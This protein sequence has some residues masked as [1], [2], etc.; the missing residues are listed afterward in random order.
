MKFQEYKEAFTKVIP[1]HA[2]NPL[3]TLTLYN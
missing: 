2:T 1:M 3:V